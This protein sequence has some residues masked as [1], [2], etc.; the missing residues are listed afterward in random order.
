MPYVCVCSYF[1]DGKVKAVS[2]SLSVL[3]V[4]EMFNALNALSEDCSLLTMPPWRNPWL[5]VAIILSLGV[6]A[7]IL[8]VP[9]MATL[10]QITAMDVNVSGC[11]SPLCR[12]RCVVTLPRRTLAGLD[13]RGRVLLPRHFD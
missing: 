8:Y 7:M 12:G 6:H 13:R 11:L 1:R 10:F 4:I 5:L 9:W 2:L 3:V